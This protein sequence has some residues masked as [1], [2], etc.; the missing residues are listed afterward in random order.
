MN[1]VLLIPACRGRDAEG[2]QRFPE[3]VLG[4][5]GDHV[6]QIFCIRQNIISMSADNRS[7]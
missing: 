3:L 6:V 7:L 5:R 1:G 2:T 4:L